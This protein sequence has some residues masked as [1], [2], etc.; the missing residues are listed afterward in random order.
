MAGRNWEKKIYEDII[1]LLMTKQRTGLSDV[2]QA[3]EARRQ[4]PKLYSLCLSKP[5]LDEP[6]N[7]QELTLLIQFVSLIPMHFFLCQYIDTMLQCVS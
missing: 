3:S 6:L 4:K 2:K 7:K 5:V 1:D